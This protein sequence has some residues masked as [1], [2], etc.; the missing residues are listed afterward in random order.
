MR[1]WIDDIYTTI[2]NNISWI[3]KVPAGL[4]VIGLLTASQASVLASQMARS[5]LASLPAEVRSGQWAFRVRV[6]RC[7]WF[8]RSSA[9]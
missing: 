4:G 7:D 2:D 3:S 1:S 8:N 9:G 6:Q 5:S